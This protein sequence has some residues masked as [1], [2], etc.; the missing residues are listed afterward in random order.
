M[1]KIPWGISDTNR[2]NSHSFV[3][4]SYFPQMSLLEGL[5]ESSSGRV[6]SYPQP[7]S[8]PPWLCTITYHPGDENYARR[9]PQFW[10]IV[11][12]RHNQSIHPLIPGNVIELQCLR[13]RKWIIKYYLDELQ[14]SRNCHAWNVD[15][16]FRILDT[17]VGLHSQPSL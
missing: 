7:A 13:G 14:A 11:S 8:S 16:N 4:S 1:L 15:S 12:P 9:W 10:D 2:Q 3:H 5:P 17:E 6:R